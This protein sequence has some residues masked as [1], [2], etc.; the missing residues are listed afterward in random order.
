M[1]K[2]QIDVRDK[3]FKNLPTLPTALK[4]V[5]EKIK[6]M[7]LETI[8]LRNLVNNHLKI[9]AEDAIAVYSV[10]NFTR[11]TMDGFALRSDDLKKA[12]KSNIVEFEII[13]ELSIKDVS[14]KSINKNQAIK[15]PTGGV[16]PTGSDCVVKIEDVEIYG[17]S[18]PYKIGIITNYHSG[19]NISHEGEDYKKGDIVFEK[20]RMITPV[21]VGVLLSVGISKIQCYKI[22]KIGVIAT[23]DEIVDEPRELEPGELYDSNSYVLVR[24]LNQ[25]GFPARRYKI[26]K[27]DFEELKERIQQIMNENDFIV[28]TGGTSVGKKDFTP[29]IL[30][31]LSDVI[32]HGIAIKPGSPTTFGIR[33]NKYYLGLPGFPVSSLI[34]FAFFG[35]PV[36]LSLMQVKNVS[37]LIMKA[38]ISEDFYSEKG[39]TGFLRVALIREKSELVAKPI[40]IAGS[41]LLHTM[42]KSDGVV[43]IDENHAKVTKNQLVDVFIIDKLVNSFV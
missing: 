37:Y 2:P 43:V 34:S 19:K 40:M 16:L 32:V 13:E 4:L 11:A 29:L 8:D 42:S 31:E 23:G 22:P 1:S 28:T 24:Y 5:F 15:I 27:D 9:L 36:L 33:E 6:P 25:L 12:S 10:P 41:S 21:D 38:R 20:G 18:V 35:V 39:K 30:N 26:I 7:E 17:S 3:G 14:N